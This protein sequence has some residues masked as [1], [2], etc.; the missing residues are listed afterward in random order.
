[1]FLAGRQMPLLPVAVSVLATSLS[2]ATFVGAPQQS[3]DGNLTYLLA[4][5]S[6]LL[7]VIFVAVFFIPAFYR[8]RV[9]SIYELV[10]A[11]MGSTARLAS[12]GMFMVG[13]VLASGARLYVMAIP[14]A[15]ITFGDAAPATL[16]CSILVV[17]AAA[18]LYTSV[19][20]IRAV[21]WTDVLQA[22]VM[23]GSVGLAAWMLLERIP[24]PVSALS[25]ALA[26]DASGNKLLL[27][28]TSTELTR[29]YTC[30]TLLSGVLLLSIASFGVDQDLTQRMLTCR[31]ARDG[32]WSVILSNLLSW[33]VQ[34]LFLGLGLL[35]YVYYRRDDVRGPAAPAYTVDDSRQVLV[36]F[37]LQE[38]PTGLRG[39]MIAGLFAAA[40]SSLD[41]VL[42]ALATTTLIDFGRRAGPGPEPLAPLT[43]RLTT[44]AWSAV[45]AAF[46]VVCVFWQRALGDTLI[47]FALRVMVFAYSG[48]LGVFLTARFTRR[49]DSRSV[50]AALIVG[51]VTVTLMQEAIW[52]RW[53]APLGGG[54][55]PAFPWQMLIATS[56]STATCCLTPRTAAGRRGSRR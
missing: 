37:V 39:L 28:D 42:N 13:R 43:I 17:A 1:M 52:H 26:A 4:N 5:L 30:W 32:S 38:L 50:V 45:L 27:L 11:E 47:N 6:N 16:V 41:S 46:A 40:M 25:Q 24:A 9:T 53:T 3:Y 8:R 29:P 7:A 54:P 15:V 36:T 2:A 23:V 20:G 35:L 51:F 19:G 55:A 33:P 10:G 56:L 48:L 14:F 22:A 44:L 49:G 34:I 18:A 31:S 21:I 12:S